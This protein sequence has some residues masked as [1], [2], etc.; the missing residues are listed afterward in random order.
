MDHEY[1][2]LLGKA[3][4][5]YEVAFHLLTV[6]FPLAKDP[7]LLLGITYN[8]TSALEYSI[9]AILAYE[10]KLKL[11]PEYKDDY[12]SKL[13]TFRFKSAP[14]NKIPFSYLSMLTTLK[15][16]QR[17]H[18]LSPLEFQRGNR[19]VLCTKN[20]EMYTLS[21]NQIKEYLRQTKS[22]VEIAERI[23]NRGF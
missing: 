5:Q 13:E 3:I 21:I 17:V 19:L 9:E 10:R 22:F 11:V 18:K 20:Y 16:L 4:Q 14:R 7:K 6:T 8:L 2:L 12:A 1:H 15:H 23:I